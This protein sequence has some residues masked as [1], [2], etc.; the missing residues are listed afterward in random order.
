VSDYHH[1]LATLLPGKEP[2]YPLNKRWGGPQ[3]QYGFG[4]KE[5]LFPCQD[6]NAG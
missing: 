3:N 1:A 6:L 5:N 4:E 2:Q